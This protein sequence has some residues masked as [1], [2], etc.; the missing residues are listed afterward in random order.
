LKQDTTAL[1]TLQL[2]IRTG[3]ELNGTL[4]AASHAVWKKRDDLLVLGKKR[5][6]CPIQQ[7]DC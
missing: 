6:I 2:T 3:G 1:A 4:L 7:D 5:R